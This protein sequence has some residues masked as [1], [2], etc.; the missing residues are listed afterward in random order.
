[1]SSS[2]SCSSA[3]ILSNFSIGEVKLGVAS[4]TDFFRWGII[5]VAEFGGFFW[6][7]LEVLEKWG[8]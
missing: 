7:G 8:L 4:V 6:G 1:V 2:C 5:G 3:Q